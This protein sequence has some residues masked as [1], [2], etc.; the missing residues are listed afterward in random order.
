[1]KIH[2]D[3]WFVVIYKKNK[4]NETFTH[5]SISNVKIGSSS[6]FYFYL[7]YLWVLC[8][9]KKDK[10][11]CHFFT[12]RVFHYILKF[13]ILHFL[14]LKIFLKFYQLWKQSLVTTRLYTYTVQA[15]TCKFW[16]VILASKCT[17]W[18]F[19]GKQM[20]NGLY[21]SITFLIHW[22]L[23][24]FYITSQHSIIHTPCKVPPI[25]HK[26]N[27]PKETLTCRLQGLISLFFKN[28]LNLELFASMLPACN[29]LPCVCW[30]IIG[31]V[32]NCWVV[33]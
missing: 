23:K 19:L 7:E 4:K 14:D 27:K 21:L 33:E 13:C 2:F 22:P 1:M 3:S 31:T 20:V 32:T 17:L 12:L 5:S 8:K 10:E 15:C 29:L 18:S 11:A 30:H 16:S 24:A 26:H 25:H 6:L 9:V 28:N